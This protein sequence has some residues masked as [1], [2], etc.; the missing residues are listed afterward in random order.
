MSDSNLAAGAQQTWPRLLLRPDR[1]LSAR[2]A[3]GDQTSHRSVFGDEP[4]SAWASKGPAA[5]QPR[6]A[7]SVNWRRR[8]PVLLVVRRVPSR[9]V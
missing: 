9:G 3:F 2:Y 1:L 4:A 7:R 5:P 6:P 8:P